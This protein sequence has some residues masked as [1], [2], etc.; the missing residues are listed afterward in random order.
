MAKRLLV[1]NLPEPDAERSRRES[2][3]RE[4]IAESERLGLYE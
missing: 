4:L 3:M 1:E 2:V